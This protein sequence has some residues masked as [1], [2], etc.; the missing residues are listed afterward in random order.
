LTIAIIVVVAP[1]MGTL[2]F[3]QSASPTPQSC[4]EGSE[5]QQGECVGSVI[6]FC[7]EGFTLEGSQCRDDANPNETPINA[8]F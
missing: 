7:P 2:A 8:Q 1:L 4:P 3:A 5:L 6:Y